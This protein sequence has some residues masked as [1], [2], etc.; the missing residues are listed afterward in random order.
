MTSIMGKFSFCHLNFQW[1]FN[2]LEKMFICFKKVSSVNK[3]PRKN[4]ESFLESIFDLKLNK[5]NT[6][7]TKPLNFEA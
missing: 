4:D 2:F 1:W 3:L 6:A 5:G 7:Y